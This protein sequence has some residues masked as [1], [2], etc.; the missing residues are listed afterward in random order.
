MGE[1]AK[2]N[3]DNYEVV[4]TEAV[5][6]LSGEAPKKE[7]EPSSEEGQ[8]QKG[9]ES[10]TAEAKDKGQEDGREAAK[11]SNTDDADDNDA[12][13]ASEDKDHRRGRGRFQKR[14]DRLTKRAAEAE[15][16]AQEAERKLKEAAKGESKSDAADDGEPDPSDFDDY[17]EYLDALTDWKAE[18]KQKGSKQEQKADDKQEGAP[19]QE[20]TDALEDVNEGFDESRK[21]YSDFD[22]VIG[23]ED[24]QI[25]REMVIAMADAEKPGEIAYHLGKN[26]QEAERISK[27]SPI[28]QARE[29]GKLEVKLA[30]KPKPGKKTTSAPD[31]IEP[32]KGSD[33][34]VKTP[35]EMDFAEFE[36]TRNESERKRGSFW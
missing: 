12:D 8:E 36:K 35:A 30:S 1:E 14:I 9:D 7:A 13:D 19:D 5:G 11:D 27:L 22:D 2:D 21:T 10:A 18:A 25:T 31:P 28:A 34:K 6:T 17:D 32:L 16:R 29:I 20:F 26:K 33:G 24:L 15:R 23:Q 4:T 3:T